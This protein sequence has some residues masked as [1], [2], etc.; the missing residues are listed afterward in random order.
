MFFVFVLGSPSLSEMPTQVPTDDIEDLLKYD[1]F[2]G[3]MGEGGN[4]IEFIEDW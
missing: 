3:V 4:E 1:L 2:G